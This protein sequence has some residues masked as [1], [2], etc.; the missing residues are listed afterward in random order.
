MGGASREMGV[1]NREMGGASREMG[2]ASREMGVANREMGGASRVRPPCP[3]ELITQS[4]VDP[5]LTP[6]LSRVDPSPELC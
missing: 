5:A 1:T 6:P 3:S 2:G 4:R